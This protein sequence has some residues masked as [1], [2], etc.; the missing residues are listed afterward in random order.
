MS[1]MTG[2]TPPPQ[3]GWRHDVMVLSLKG[4]P[5]SKQ[6]GGKRSP[7]VNTTSSPPCSFIRK[8]SLKRASWS[9]RVSSNICTSTI[10]RSELTRVYLNWTWIMMIYRG[11]RGGA[12]PKWFPDL[13]S[14]R[15][16]GFYSW[17]KCFNSQKNSLINTNKGEKRKLPV[18]SGFIKC[19][20]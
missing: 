1:L 19:S 18:S 20:I 4:L 10:I 12:G 13:Y 14:F 2:W 7:C 17:L 16:L 11:T 9:P 6:R 8:F 5:D 15:L 3:D